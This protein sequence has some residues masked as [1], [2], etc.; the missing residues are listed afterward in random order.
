MN[1]FSCDFFRLL[2]CPSTKTSALP[3]LIVMSLKRLLVGSISLTEDLQL[4]EE[5]EEKQSERTSQEMDTFQST[6][7]PGE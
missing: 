1:I 7:R 6:G 4:D 5:N 3:S 2:P